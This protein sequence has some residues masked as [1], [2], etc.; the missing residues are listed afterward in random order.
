MAHQTLLALGCMGKISS[1]S[2]GRE[3]GNPGWVLAF[4]HRFRT[5]LRVAFAHYS[6]A[7]DISGVSSWLLRFATFLRQQ[8]VDVGVH[9]LNLAASADL[10]S[11]LE[12]ALR[13]AGVETFKSPQTPHL[14]TDVQATLSFLNAWQPDVFL[15]QCKS[16]H[17]IAAA[18]AG[19]SG[20]P[21][22]LT[23]HSDDP[24]YWAVLESLPPQGSGGKAVC[25]SRHIQAQLVHHGGEADALVIPCGVAIP[26][27]AAIHHTR[28]FR[29]VYCGRLWDHQKR[30][31]LVVQSL[32]H[33]CQRSDVEIVATVIGEGYGRQ[34]CEQLVQK[35]G[36][37]DRITF[38]G[39][40]PF[41]A[42][43]TILL[44]SQAILLMSDFEGLPVALLEGM[45]AGVVPVARSI[46]SGI[47][48]LVQDQETGLLVGESPEEAGAALARL[49]KDSAL[50]QHCSDQART[51]VETAYS[52]VIS[53]QKWL[54][55]LLELEKISAPSYPIR[56]FNNFNFTQLSPLLT[57][58]YKKKSSLQ[59]LQLKRRARTKLARLKGGLKQWLQTDS[60]RDAS[61][62]SRDA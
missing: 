9:L 32:I 12:L 56:G 46:P 57:L 17:Y 5:P 51:L 8:N 59:S 54:N 31:T 14:K 44:E 60:T 35:A 53:N 20:L 6:S 49:A 52:E 41:A 42:I 24:D 1:R 10:P 4:A 15:P 25:V 2:L 28:P 48:E 3:G 16:P 47:P 11:P 38:V 45:A 33:A 36:L 62:P 55:C 43:Q 21:W 37:G 19:R 27:R 58:P 23:L 18:I 40:Q 13:E 61:N 22:V 39:L 7:D 30:I 50:W 29:V 34:A 26:D